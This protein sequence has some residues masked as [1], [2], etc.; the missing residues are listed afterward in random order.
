MAN[1]FERCDFNLAA[2]F[3]EIRCFV[4]VLSIKEVVS[5]TL[6][7]STFFKALLNFLSQIKFCLRLF[8][9]ARK[10]FF[11]DLEIGKVAPFGRSNAKCKSQ[12]AKLNVKIQND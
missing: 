9:A 7:L 5:L 8:L 6:V 1:F 11:A 10:D 2:L 4:A 3:L 12:N